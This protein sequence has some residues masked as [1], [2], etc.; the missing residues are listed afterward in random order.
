MANKLRESFALLPGRAQPWIRIAKPGQSGI[1]KF[2][3]RRSVA[4]GTLPV[5]RPPKYELRRTIVFNSH[6]S[7]PMVN[8][9]GLPDSAPGNNGNNIDLLVCPGIVQESD[10][11]LPTKNIAPGDW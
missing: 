10:I 5:E 9:R 3:G 1:E 2:I 8:E 6:S 7:E 4:P 11:L